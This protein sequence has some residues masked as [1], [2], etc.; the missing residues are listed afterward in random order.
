MREQLSIE[1]VASKLLLSRGQVLGLEQAEAAPF[2]SNDYFLRGLRKYM[3]FMGLPQ[4]RFSSTTK[5]ARKKAAC[6]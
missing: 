3:A 4:G 2:Y 5:R 6:G 1:A